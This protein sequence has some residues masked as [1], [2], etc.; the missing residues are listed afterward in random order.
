MPRYAQLVMG[1]A[2]S[3]KVRQ[4]PVSTLKAQQQAEADVGG[5]S[6]HATLSPQSCYCSTLVRH[7]GTLGR[8]VQVVNL[9]PAA[10]YFN[11]PVMA[12]EALGGFI[13]SR[14]QTRHPF[15]EI[16]RQQRRSEGKVSFTWKCPR[17]TAVL[18]NG[19]QNRAGL[20]LAH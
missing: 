12:G 16:P 8:S 5:C 3:G 19:L 18:E 1:P 15:S 7:C 6:A 4:A 14:V 20:V 9:D 11:Y 17:N 10:E 2:G 13:C